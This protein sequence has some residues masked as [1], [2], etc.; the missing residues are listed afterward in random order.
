LSNSDD[1]AVEIRSLS[2]L[3]LSGKELRPVHALSDLNLTVRREERIAVL[4]PSGCGKSTLLRVLAGLDS[5]YLGEV[6][7]GV[8]AAS[9]DRLKSA[10]VFQQDSTFPWMTVD[11]NIHL[12]MSSLS[13]S[14]KEIASRTEHYLELVGLSGFGSSLPNQLSG[15]MRQRVAIA[16]ALAC[17]PRVLLMD[18]PFAALDAQTRLVMQSE[19]LRILNQHAAT[20]LYVTHDIEEAA[21]IADRIIVMSSRPGRIISERKASFGRASVSPSRAEQ[22]AQR[23]TD[24]FAS[25]TQALWA[26]LATQVGEQL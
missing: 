10:T 9:R 20:M 14:S 2:K 22:M 18:E 8:E 19:L 12:G 26:D 24:E 7:W 25:L 1:V 6:K 5:Q 3:Y 21:A 17:N 15:G 23:G 11:Q 13:L 16:R 4:G